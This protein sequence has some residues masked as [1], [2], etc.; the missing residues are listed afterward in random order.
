M[1]AEIETD[2]TLSV[3]GVAADAKAVGDAI[4]AIEI[5]SIDG[6][7]TEEYVNNLVRNSISLVDQVTGQV[8]VISMRD[9][10]LVSTL[11]T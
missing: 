11:A 5:P 7:A 9:G 2:A 3:E 4:A 8:Y 10:N 6:L 1:S